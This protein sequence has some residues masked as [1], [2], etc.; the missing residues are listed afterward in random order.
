MIYPHVHENHIPV[1]RLP[2]GII[3][4]PGKRL[5]TTPGL[6][7]LTVHNTA[8]HATD[9]NER[10][11]LTNPSNKR[12]ASWHWSCDE[13]SVTE[14]VPPDEVAYHAGNTEGNE[15]S[16][17]LEITERPGSERTA[18]QW[19]GSLIAM[20]Q[21]IGIRVK[22]VTHR[23]WSG[24]DCPR[25]ILPRWSEF[26]AACHDE[27]A[28]ILKGGEIVNKPKDWETAA[29]VKAVSEL[30]LSPEWIPKAGEPAS[31]GLICELLNRQKTRGIK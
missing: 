28:R 19:I 23:S 1:G 15:T 26:V 21:K 13:D 9:E 27:A 6:I 7:V 5:R 18:I 25:L 30:G 20:N 17:S 3:R 4:R 16:V 31:V 29:V 2:S 12:A 8:N 22:L 24:K 14:A 10:G 11:W